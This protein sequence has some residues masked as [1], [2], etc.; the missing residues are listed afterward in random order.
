MLERKGTGQAPTREAP[1]QAKG[2]HRQMELET[3]IE[4]AKADDP[5][6]F[7]ELV[8][9][10]VQEQVVTAT[11]ALTQEKTKA[12]DAVSKMEAKRTEMADEYK[13]LQRLLRDREIDGAE[14]LAKVLDGDGQAAT[15]DP[16]EIRR[17]RT[18][19]ETHRTVAET[20]T[21]AAE[22]ALKAQA[23]AEKMATRSRSAA[24]DTLFDLALTRTTTGLGLDKK[25]RPQPLP[26]LYQPLKN[27]LRQFV[28]Y[29]DVEVGGEVER[30]LF[31]VHNGTPIIGPA[32]TPATV[33]DLVDMGL[34]GN[35]DAAKPWTRD[36][37][38]FFVSRGTGGNAQG[39]S[40]GA[41]AGA[42]RVTPEMLAGAKTMREYEALR[43]EM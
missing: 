20:Q 31:A 29:R 15:P 3:L 33:A 7:G 17:L 8:Q 21:A 42:G 4:A 25:P 39:R 5:Q 40:G 43:N 28:E 34:L 38:D 23:S 37:R 30:Q 13:P 26:I 10:H 12:Q 19:V 24:D 11:A 14:A 9:T 36:I 41:N 35:P 2:D 32:G 22:A 6:K 27:H 1:N 16:E 18:E